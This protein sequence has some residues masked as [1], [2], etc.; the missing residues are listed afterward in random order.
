MEKGSTVSVYGNGWLM[1]REPEFSLHPGEA[2][3]F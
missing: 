1:Q 3:E 2:N